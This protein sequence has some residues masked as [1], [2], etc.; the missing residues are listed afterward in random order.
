MSQASAAD[1]AMGR[2]FVVQW[3]QDLALLQQLCV[4]R[5]RLGAALGN[6]FLQAA[7]GAD[8]CECQFASA[9]GVF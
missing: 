3:R 6:F 2:V 4:V 1:Q 9:V 7:L 5:A 8:R